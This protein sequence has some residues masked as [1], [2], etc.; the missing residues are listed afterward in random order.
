VPGSYQAQPGP[1]VFILLQD[2]ERYGTH[3]FP[4]L[5]DLNLPLAAIRINWILDWKGG[6][7]TA[8]EKSFCMAGI[9]GPISEA[10]DGRP[11]CGNFA[12]SM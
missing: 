1:G 4:C 10:E 5:K 11:Q 7:K 2:L 9:N 8:E 6:F 12:V 3:F